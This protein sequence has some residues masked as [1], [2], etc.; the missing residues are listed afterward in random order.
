MNRFPMLNS[1]RHL[2]HGCILQQIVQRA[3]ISPDTTTAVLTPN[4]LSS[5]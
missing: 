5:G 2:F 1:L 4:R 3:G